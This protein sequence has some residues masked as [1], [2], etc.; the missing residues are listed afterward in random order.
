MVQ[1]TQS[2][3]QLEDSMNFL[4]Q[5]QTLQVE[6]LTRLIKQEVIKTQ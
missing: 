2:L 5:Y 3:A 6:Y 4:A 1:Q